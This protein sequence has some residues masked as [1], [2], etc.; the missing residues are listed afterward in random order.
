MGLR[1]NPPPGWPPAPE[2]FAPP[3]GW[4]PDPSW[5]PP[6]PGWQLW[7]ND[8][9][10]STPAS[11]Q[12]TIQAGPPGPGSPYD[13]PGPYGD[14]ASPYGGSANPYGSP[15]GPYG[16]PG[17]Q[18]GGAGGPYG[19]PYG[20]YGNP[21]AP[22]GQP[23]S[24]KT[25]G[26]AIA[27]FILGLLGAVLLSVIFAF[28]AL[29]RIKRLGQRGRGFAIAGLVLSG[30]WVLLVIL[31]VV[32]ANLN[33]ASRSSSTGKITHSGNLSV[34]SLAVGDCFNSPADTQDV[35]SVTAEPCNQPHS[36]QIYAKFNLAGSNFSYPGTAAVTRLAASG[37]T[38]RTGNIDR[39]KATNAMTV[40]FLFPDQNAWL[41][42]RRT[43]ACM[44][45]N[46]TANLTYSLLNP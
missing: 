33:G 29:S 12:Q 15:T 22:T 24:R 46:P 36:A 43:V 41:G 31:I 23:Y 19:T 8:D 7:V 20:G 4:Q 2:G 16:T 3:P 34:F 37:C 1:Y 27:S 14:A 38:A 6:P 39:S 5:P 28:I 44:I 32:V 10:V 26:W 9:Q 11:S 42:G 30:I 17:G 13:G 35:A 45:V 18:Y 40:R 21:Y 25:S